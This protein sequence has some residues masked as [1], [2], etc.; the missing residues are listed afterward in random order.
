M[1][2]PLSHGTLALAFGSLFPRSLLPRKLWL[3]GVCCAALPDVDI[4]SFRLG[5]PYQHMLGHRG[6]THSISF[7]LLLALVV[8]GFTMFSERGRRRAWPFGLYLFACTLSHGL[9][10]AITKGGYGVAFFAPFLSRRYL[11]PWRVIE[12]APLSVKQFLSTRGLHI[13]GVELMWVVLPCLLITL[14]ACTVW[15][16]LDQSTAE[17]PEPRS[18]C[19]G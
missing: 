4:L 15:A 16:M 7:A 11:F 10:D 18:V 8:A 9:L 2:S 14:L 13:V 3:V 12:A 17:G 19:Q 1:P 6:L 5:I